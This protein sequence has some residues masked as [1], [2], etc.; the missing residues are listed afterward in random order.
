MSMKISNYNLEQK[1]I[2]YS[3]TLSL[4]EGENYRTCAI[5]PSNKYLSVGTYNGYIIQFEIIDA[6]CLPE[7]NYSCFELDN[8]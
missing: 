3:Q 8:I 6:H 7:I 4:M 1:C 5:S 2:T